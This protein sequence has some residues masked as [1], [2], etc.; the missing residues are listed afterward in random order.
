MKLESKL[1]S[2]IYVLNI[3]IKEESFINYKR[4]AFTDLFYNIKN[5]LASF[6]YKSANLW[7]LRDF[8]LDYKIYFN[9]I[10]EYKI[11]E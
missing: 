2:S 1:M 9:I 3:I 8:L 6:I 4:A 10:R 7:E 5:A 11:Y